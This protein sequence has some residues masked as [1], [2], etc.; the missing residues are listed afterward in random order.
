MTSDRD[1]IKI[2]FVDDE[3]LVLKAL[4]RTLRN[5]GFQIFITSDPHDA[6]RLVGA[7][8]IDIVV[9]DY[10]MPGMTGVD[11]LALMRTLHPRTFRVMLTGQ[12]DREAAIRA[13]NEGSIHRFLEK[14][15]DEA[16]LKNVLHEAARSIAVQRAVDS[17]PGTLPRTRSGTIQRDASGAIIL[18]EPV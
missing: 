16:M 6:A 3:E 2:L 17:G 11:V 13:I 14:P 5:E 4:R 1:T 8:H 18:S 7:E 12:A 15:W 10:L 9:S